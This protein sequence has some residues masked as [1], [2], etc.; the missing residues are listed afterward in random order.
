MMD[1]LD[2]GPREGRL[3]IFRCCAPYTPRPKQAH[4]SS[5]V[6]ICQPRSLLVCGVFLLLSAD[7]EGVDMVAAETLGLR[8]YQGTSRLH[9]REKSSFACTNHYGAAISRTEASPRSPEG[10]ELRKQLPYLGHEPR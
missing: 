8:F 7:R 2:K 9:R 4:I 6:T 10:T 3:T 5:Q 1:E